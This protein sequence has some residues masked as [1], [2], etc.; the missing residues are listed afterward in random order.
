MGGKVSRQ[1][2]KSF[3]RILLVLVLIVCAV[4]VTV[5]AMSRRRAGLPEPATTTPEQPAETETGTRAVVLYFGAPDGSDLVEVNREIPVPSDPSALLAGV[6]KE[7][8]TGPSDK[9]V[10]VLPAGTQ[11][12]SAYIS[13]NDAYVDFSSELKSGFSGGSTEEYLLIASVVRTVAENFPDIS[14]VQILVEGKTV[15]SLGGHYEI[16]EPLPVGEWE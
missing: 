11:V 12:R 7:L 16:T 3:Y 6:M 4:L 9:G 10:A 15:D 8:A 5:V 14:R 1:N 2:S 13:G